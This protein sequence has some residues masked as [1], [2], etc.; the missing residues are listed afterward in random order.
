MCGGRTGNASSNP[1]KSERAGASLLP[2]FCVFTARRLQ[3]LLVCHPQN[4]IAHAGS[5]VERLA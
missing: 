2:P 5:A 3:L 1:E 4:R